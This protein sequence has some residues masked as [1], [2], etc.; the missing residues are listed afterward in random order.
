MTEVTTQ[1]TETTAEQTPAL[2]EQLGG[3]RIAGLLSERLGVEVTM[4]DIDELVAQEHLV[5]LGQ[6]RS[7]MA[8]LLDRSCR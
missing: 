6:V 2:P 8:C 1:A 7:V 4:A 3:W 5:G